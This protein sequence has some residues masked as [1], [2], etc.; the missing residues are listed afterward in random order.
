MLQDTTVLFFI[1]LIIFIFSWRSEHHSSSG[2]GNSTV[3]NLGLAY[4]ILTL[5]TDPGS[6][7]LGCG[8]H[9]YLFYLFIGFVRE[10]LTIFFQDLEKSL[11]LIIPVNYT[12]VA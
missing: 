12:R 5:N 1:V 9:V 3:F 10:S 11:S 6:Y 7:N 8:I 4:P 2:F